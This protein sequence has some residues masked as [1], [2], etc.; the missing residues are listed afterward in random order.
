LFV[1]LLFIFSNLNSLS[2]FGDRLTIMS[3]CLLLL[4]DR[5]PMVDG[6]LSPF[7]DHNYINQCDRQIGE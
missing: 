4:N 5:L 1:Y 6:R 7:A 3:D 2:L